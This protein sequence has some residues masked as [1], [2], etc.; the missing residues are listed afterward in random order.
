MGQFQLCR[1]D[2]NARYIV[3]F[4]DAQFAQFYMGL[5]VPKE[6]QAEDFNVLK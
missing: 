2:Q 4:I 1:Q 3:L 5:C 6:C